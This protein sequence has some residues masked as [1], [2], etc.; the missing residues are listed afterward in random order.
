MSTYWQYRGEGEQPKASAV[1]HQGIHLAESDLGMAAL[2]LRL[3]R[4]EGWAAEQRQVAHKRVEKR[5]GLQVTCGHMAADLLHLA[6]A[7][8]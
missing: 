7:R 5:F 3:M 1:E 8:E 4:D 6:G 2:T